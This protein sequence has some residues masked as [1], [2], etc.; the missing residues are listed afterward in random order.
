MHNNKEQ[1]YINTLLELEQC[2]KNSTTFDKG[3]P[4]LAIKIFEECTQEEWNQLQ[5][6]HNLHEWIGLSLKERQTTKEIQDIFKDIFTV[7]ESSLESVKS[8]ARITHCINMEM[9]RVERGAGEFS[10]LAFNLSIHDA[11]LKQNPKELQ[12]LMESILHSSIRAY[13]SLF[14]LEKKRFVLILPGASAYNARLFAKRFVQNTTHLLEEQYQYSIILHI[15]VA[16][17]KSGII[18]SPE[19]MLDFAIEALEEALVKDSSVLQI[20]SHLLGEIDRE[21]IV[22]EEERA[23]LFTNSKRNLH[24]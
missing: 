2:T 21:S 6:Q 16:T 1:N 18:L 19:R 10:I 11:S 22:K 15:G 7:A 17:Y 8:T 5:K 24:E 23:F 9:Q 13:D 12:N 4:L 20:S 3:N 14:L